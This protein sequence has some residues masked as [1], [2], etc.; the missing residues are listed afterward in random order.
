MHLSHSDMEDEELNIDMENNFVD[1]G[2]SHQFGS[3]LQKDFLSSLEMPL[4][5]GKC[6]FGESWVKFIL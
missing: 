5:C 4:E 1:I 3:K 2:Y 6:S